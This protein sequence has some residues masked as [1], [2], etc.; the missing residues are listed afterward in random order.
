MK[1]RS[2]LSVL[3]AVTMV[4]SVALTGCG[5]NDAADDGAADAN[6]EVEEGGEEADA[7]LPTV[8]FTHGYY[9]DESEWAPAAEMRAIYQEF[10]DAHADEF[11]FVAVADQTGAEGIY[12]T[13]LNDLASGDFYDIA[14]FGGWDITGV[15]AGADAILDLKPY[16]DADADL[17]AGVGVC[18]DQNLT[19]DG[20]IYSVREQ[21][22]GVGFWYNE[23]L[24]AQAGA[25][26]PDQW[27]SWADFDAAVDALV[28]AGISPF[29][30]NAGW[31]TNI[32]AAGIAQ[33]DEAAREFYANGKAVESFD[34]DAFKGTLEFLQ[35]NV[36]AKIDAAHFGPGGDDDNQYSLDFTTGDSAM[37]FNGVWATGEFTDCEAGIENLKPAVFPTNDG[38]KA[39]LLSGGCG[40]VVSNK[41][42]EEQ[43][44]ICIEFIKY[45]TSPE[46]ASR[47]VENG[48]GMVPS[49]AVDYSTITVES[50][51]GQL[52]VEACKLLQS[53]DVKVLGWGNTFGDM[54]GEIQNKYA[55]LKDGSKTV[56][57]VVSELD[58]AM[59]AAE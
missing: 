11:N 2:I 15:A 4:A 1:K 46:V 28:A 52:L 21:I 58:Q 20:K 51:A 47:I 18:Y 37:Y 29:S 40:F 38:K 44:E 5:A 35:N 26:T 27:T 36:L 10:A 48:I 57:D 16:L 22:E 41:L 30:L 34:N 19:E 32:L 14:D 17:K 54:E 24:F 7:E 9:H 39:G 43:T 55:G 12:N 59:A 49:D 25:T 53:A 8:T 33:R 50:P 45:M 6:T 23:A 3:L 42:T 31:P 56:E 13:A